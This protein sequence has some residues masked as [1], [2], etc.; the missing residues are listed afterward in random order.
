MALALA[1]PSSMAG[2][3]SHLSTQWCS[4]FSSFKLDIGEKKTKYTLRRHG[5]G[6]VSLLA[7]MAG[8]QTQSFLQINSAITSVVD[9]KLGM[10]NIWAVEL[11]YL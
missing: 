1:L 3:P 5:P 9:S 7:F 4:I 6:W 8:H 11:T 2:N 10:M